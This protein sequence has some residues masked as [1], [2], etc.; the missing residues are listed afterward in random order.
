M[1]EPTSLTPNLDHAPRGWRLALRLSVIVAG[2]LTAVLGF[3]VLMLLLMGLHRIGLDGALANML[4][5]L[6]SPGVILAGVVGAMRVEQMQ[7]RRL[8]RLL[9]PT[10]DAPTAALG[11]TAAPTAVPVL[12]PQP[13]QPP[14]AR[15]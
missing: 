11:S 10:A 4:M 2:A 13:A 1:D 12:A 5:V 3:G 15:R 9:A 14:R 7:E 6:L 8:Q